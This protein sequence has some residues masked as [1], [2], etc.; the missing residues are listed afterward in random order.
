[1]LLFLLSRAGRA[2]EFNSDMENAES[3]ACNI[4]RSAVVS[5]EGGDSPPR[6][7]SP[8]PTGVPNSSSQRRSLAVDDAFHESAGA[9][10]DMVVI[11]GRV[12]D[13]GTDSPGMPYDGESPRRKVRVSSFLI[14]KYEVSN[15]QYEEFVRDTG[16]ITDSEK[17]NWSFVLFSSLSRA[18]QKQ[19]TMWVQDAPWWT[20][21]E[22]SYWR[23]PEGPGSDVF[24]SESAN[25]DRR[26]HPA[27]HISWTDAKA[28]CEWRGGSR[29]P[30]EAE[31]E[32][33]ARGPSD[34]KV[35]PWGNVL[36]PNGTRRLNIYEGDFP[37]RNSMEDGYAYTAPV[38]AY[39]PQ[40]EYGVYNMVG[41]VWEWV[42]DW[43]ATDHEVSMGEE[44][45]EAVQ[46]NPRGPDKGIEKVKKGGSFLCHKKFCYRYRNAARFKVEVDNGTQNSGF[47]CAKDI[48]SE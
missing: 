1:M 48:V 6:P 5:N 17:W 40:N 26:Q 7:P 29:L 12:F 46:E 33:A 3:C 35:F 15:A 11:P 2:G 38:D 16:H 21:V 23:A 39:G 18:K 14:D 24:S 8:S 4:P 20:Q 19:V 47:R 36:A 43:W 27:V 10:R 9:D 22:G 13:M 34:R 25:G 42:D 28:F 30:T 32:L 37:K 41:N 31:W 44:G 45:S